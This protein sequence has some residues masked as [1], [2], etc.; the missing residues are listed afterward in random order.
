M[1]GHAGRVD[2]SGTGCDVT[3]TRPFLLVGPQRSGTTALAA[4]LS[5]AI[6]TVGGCFTVNGKLLYLLRRWWTD[7]DGEAQHLRADE[8]A[9]A[10]ERLPAQGPG[11]DA[12]Q[13]RAMD[14]LRASARRGGE[15]T[16]ST[17]DEVRRIC[18]EAYGAGPWGDKYNEY[19]LDLPWLH[20]VFPDARWVFLIREPGE[21][22]ASMLAWRHDKPWN[23]RDAEAA[24]TKW[25]HWTSCWLAFRDTLAPHQRIELEYA[26]LCEGRQD[27]LSE[28]VGIDLTPFLTTFRRPAAPD[29]PLAPLGARATDVRAALVGLGLLRD[30][31]KG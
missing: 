8:V 13:T 29:R 30:R 19:L 23:P 22:V 18:A 21:A 24:S 2:R 6:V 1:H 10:L 3:A 9:H 11:A 20:A 7:P 17:I 16:V 5:A 26:A 31:I 4:A 14:A 15:T 28:L 27:A 25:A 12:W